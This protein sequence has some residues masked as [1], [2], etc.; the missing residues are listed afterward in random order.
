MAYLETASLKEDLHVKSL[1]KIVLLK[2]GL[3]Y[4]QE[5][6]PSDNRIFQNGQNRHAFKITRFVSN[7]AF[8]RPKPK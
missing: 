6:S 8:R 7:A 5:Q 3:P 1:L 4:K 2:K